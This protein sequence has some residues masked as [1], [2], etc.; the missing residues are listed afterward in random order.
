[1]GCLPIYPVLVEHFHSFSGILIGFG[2][3]E[4]S[5]YVCKYAHVYL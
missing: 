5:A 4:L 2:V 3:F 1:M